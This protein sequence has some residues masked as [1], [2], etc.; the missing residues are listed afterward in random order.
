MRYAAIIFAL[1]ILLLGSAGDGNAQGNACGVSPGDWCA[2]PG[3]A[4][5]RHKTAEACK[6]DRQ[7]Y[8][9]GYRGESVV[10]CVDDGQGRGF[11]SNCPTVGCTSAPLRHDA[12]PGSSR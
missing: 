7:C 1:L 6:A 9:I 11:A 10:A 5:N 12:R 8:G 3:D 4:C 2:V